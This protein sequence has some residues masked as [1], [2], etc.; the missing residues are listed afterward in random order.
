MVNPTLEAFQSL[1]YIILLVVAGIGLRVASVRVKKVGV[2]LK[3]TFKLLNFFVIWVILPSVVFVSVGKFTANQI[4]GFGNAFLLAFVGLGVC[5]VS[6]VLV[7]SAAKDNRNT[8]IAMVLSSGFQN[9]TYLGFPA[10]AILLGS[11]YLAPAA[12]YAMGIGIPHIIIGTM[13]ASTAAKRKITARRVTMSV[14]TFPAAFALLAA[15]LFVLFQAP[16]PTYMHQAF[17]VYLT[18]P[19]FALMLVVVGYQIPLVS[20]HRYV[21]ELISVGSFRFVVGPIV[22]FI[23]IL[24]L[25]LSLNPSSAVGSARPSLLLSAMPPAVFNVILAHNFKLDTKLYGAMVFYLTL[26]SLLLVLPVVSA[27]IS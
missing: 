20:P 9:V 26:V 14:L 15:L 22:T 4:L 13:L 18:P 19:F 2:P 16:I 1:A 11:Q 17:D 7:S 27:F 12:L 6:A 24:A 21:S 5:F 25:G 8:T 23:A 10:V 3:K